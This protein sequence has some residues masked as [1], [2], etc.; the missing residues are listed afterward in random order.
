M[1]S[2]R[3]DE[4]LLAEVGPEL[5][6]GAYDLLM[7]SFG[8]AAFGLAL[9]ILTGLGSNLGTIGGILFSLGIIGLFVIPIFV[10]GYTY[11]ITTNRIV[12]EFDFIIRSNSMVRYSRIT[13]I[14]P[15]QGV[16]DRVFDTG[17]I[18]IHT[19][20]SHQKAIKI[21]WIKEFED[22]ESIITN[23]LESGDTNSY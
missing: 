14:H 2:L 12:A 9:L 11:Y 15:Q 18:G 1:F 8:G 5:E 10:A 16:F 6:S 7:L 17:S 19:A 3:D 4:E 20:G 13:D 23:Q 22:V 21:S